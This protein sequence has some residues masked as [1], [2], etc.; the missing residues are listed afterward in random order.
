M[1]SCSTKCTPSSTLHVVIFSF[2]VDDCFIA[3][4]S[5]IGRQ[6]GHVVLSITVLFTAVHTRPVVGTVVL[7]GCAHFCH[8][9]H[10]I[11][12]CVLIEWWLPP[13]ACW[14]CKGMDNVLVTSGALVPTAGLDGG[15]DSVQ[16]Y[17]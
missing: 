5:W 2:H 15:W 7:H 8:G 11:A 17:W 16:V 6:R 12:L 4:F 1:C 14:S 10:D 13:I 9:S 3:A